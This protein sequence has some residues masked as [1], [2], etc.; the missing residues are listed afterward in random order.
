M[1]NTTAEATEAIV[2]LFGGIRPMATKLDTP[3]TT[4]QGW[5]KRGLIPQARHADILA[6][7]QRETIA[8]DPA[9]LAATDPGGIGSGRG[10]PRAPEEGAPSAVVVPV[11][12]RRG[13]AGPLALV[14]SLV[15]LVGITAAG[16]GAWRFYIEPLQGRVAAL[17]AR[18]TTDPATASA[19][20]DLRARLDG[21]D[22]R[23]TEG[24]GRAAS[25]MGS[26]TVAHTASI[27]A[28]GVEP[29]RLAQLEKQVADL[30]AGAAETAQLAKRLSDLQMAA[31][32]RELL[33]Q[34]I[35]DI[36][37]STAATQGQVERLTKQLAGLTGRVD[38]VDAALARR[39]QQ[40]LR[41]EAVMLAVGEL[42][43]ALRT[44][45][46]FAKE[47]ASV[48]ALAG[49]DADINSVL[50]KIQ[51]NAD[52]GV[53]SMD[54]LRTDFGHLAPDIVRSAVVGDGSKWWR[55][56]LYHIESVISVRRVGDSVKGDAVDAVVARAEAKLEEDD[57][58]GAVQALQPLTGLS[59]DVAQPWIHD[60]RDRLALNAAEAELTRLSIDRVAGNPSSASDQSGSDQSGADQTGAQTSAP[61]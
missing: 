37:S 31:G 14:L 60:A 36:Q 59:S 52:D 11:V 22:S 26:T 39:K 58:K 17:E 15:I 49:G 54:D 16:F 34:S 28:G 57:L 24:A 61:Q 7:A 32:G 45:G 12:R 35:M 19:L 4:V 46:A 25:D 44:N 8:L 2:D 53:P 42:R 41:A 33:T 38:T 40:S 5:K 6:A 50:D 47:V 55:Q 9:V 3:V 51:P 43:A 1:D 13:V 30:K 20:T 21:L 29:D 18:P 56:A 48:R 23:V 10:E 27:S